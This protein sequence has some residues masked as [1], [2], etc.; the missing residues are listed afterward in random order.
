MYSRPLN[1]LLLPLLYCLI[2]GTI[3]PR[4]LEAETFALPSSNDAVIG[5]IE[6][7]RSR[8]EET[9]IDIAREFDLGYDQIVKANPDVNRWIPGND[10]KVILPHRYILPG[11][12]RKGVVL[13]IPELRLYYYPPVSKGMPNSVYT[14]PVSIGRMDWKTPIGTT[15]V[16]RKDRDPAWRPTQSIREEHARDGDILPAVIPGGSPENPLGRFALRLGFPE[17]L[18]HGVDE[19]KTYG[20]GMRVTHGCIRMYPSDIE[21]LFPMVA[22]NTPVE[23]MNDSMKIGWL[24]DHLFLEVH[25]PLN[26]GEDEDAPELPRI[27]VSEVLRFVR[28]RVPSYVSFD[29]DK[30][31]AIAE[32]GDGVP[33]EIAQRPPQSFPSAPQEFDDRSY[34]APKVLETNTDKRVPKDSPVVQ[35]Q[36]EYEKA[37]ARHLAPPERPS[38]R[39]VAVDGEAPRR[40]V[41]PRAR[42]SE[43]SA[44]RYIEE[45]Y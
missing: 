11:T 13:N 35:I 33:R 14:F 40:Q 31:A 10:T 15:K 24:D 39:S 29:E 20:I 25:Q 34:E 30:V 2:G 22:V 6:H 37:I 27:E 4:E 36:S 21:S 26:E 9:L 32:T 3:S 17:Y 43:G 12:I 45:R 18:I 23:I 41:E 38:Q 19:R 28:A 1:A 5:A 7:V 16:V 8:D 42:L 44:R